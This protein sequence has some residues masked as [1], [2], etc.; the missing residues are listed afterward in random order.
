MNV[1]A[2]VDPLGGTPALDISVHPLTPDA[3][4]WVTASIDDPR[5]H[6]D[7]LPAVSV[8]RLLASMVDGGCPCSLPRSRSRVIAT[9]R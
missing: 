5:D 3:W 2:D 8:W 1:V 7:T 4:Y 9:T 6:S